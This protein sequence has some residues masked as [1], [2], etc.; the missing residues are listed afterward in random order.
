MINFMILIKSLVEEIKNGG[1]YT[2]ELAS[3]KAGKLTDEATAAIE[4]AA[5]EVSAKYQ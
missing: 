1:R 2:A 5:A 3:L 4:S